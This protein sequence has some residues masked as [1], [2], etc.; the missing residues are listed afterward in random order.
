MACPLGA[1]ACAEPLGPC[2]T[3]LDFQFS[4][5]KGP[6]ASGGRQITQGAANRGSVGE[7]VLGTASPSPSCV[8]LG[9]CFSLSELWWLHLVPAVITP[10]PHRMV[11]R[12]R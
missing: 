4:L 12:M 1:R 3:L 11:I 5:Q 7:T 2:S 6:R 8:A 10:V 9:Q